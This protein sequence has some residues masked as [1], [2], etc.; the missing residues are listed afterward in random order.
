M[1]INK[2]SFNENFFEE[3]AWNKNRSVFGIDEVGRGCL[4]GPVVTATVELINKN[5]PYFII[6]S[7]ALNSNDLLNSYN[8]LLKNSR[9]SI[10]IVNCHNI[11]KLN[12][13]N[14]TLLCMKKSTIGLFYKT[15]TIPT[16]ILV[17]SMPLELN[18]TIYNKI[19]IYSFDKGESKSVSIAS[20]SIIAKVTRDRLLEKYEKIFP[21]FS[22]GEH[23]GYGTA[24]HN[25]EL[26]QNGSTIIH[27]KTFFI[28]SDIITK[29]FK[30][31][32][33]ILKNMSFFMQKTDN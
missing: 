25:K 33:S 4:A 5:I 15:K 3:I 31:Q 16:A 22:F 21:G 32:M 11:D 10:G 24:N 28:K 18:N 6:D 19:P 26:E 2:N 30:N 7:K 20:A 29:D 13:W 17:D 12:I 14:A 1:K 23:K 9:F 8:W 27:R